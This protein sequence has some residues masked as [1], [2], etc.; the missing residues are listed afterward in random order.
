MAV[1]DFES[2][3]NAEYDNALN[4]ISKELFTMDKD[5]DNDRVR[6]MQW[7]LINLLLNKGVITKEEF[8]S[9]VEEATVFFKLLKR[10]F[11]LQNPDDTDDSTENS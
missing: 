4:D 1:Q 7:G 11:K 6:L 2:L 9:S 5:L 10:R 8:E 3:S